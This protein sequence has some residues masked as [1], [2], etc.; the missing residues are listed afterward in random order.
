MSW[1][2]LGSIARQE[3]LP[4]SDVDTALVWEDLPDGPP[5]ARKLQRWADRVLGNME[6]CGLQR[7]VDG[8]NA[9]NPIFAQSKSAFTATAASWIQNPTQS[10]ALLLSSMIAD[11]RPL[12][13]IPLGRAVSDAML[14][15][16]RSREYLTRLLRYST[17]ARPPVGF[18]RNFVV[19]HSG[20]N[21]GQLN[22]KAG[23]LVPIASL[24]RW[25]AI[26]T[27]NDRGTTITRLRRGQDEGLLTTDE[28]DTLIR[29]F[30]YIYGLLLDHEITA[31][32]DG[33][34]APTTWIA[35]R[36]LDTLTRRYLREAFRA[37]A[38]VQ[39]RLEGLWVSRLP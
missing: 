37:V 12:T 13:E 15:T 10:D 28:T 38:E 33:A 7:C 8:A 32:R 9:T 4:R 2:V 11:S 27:G 25:I 23:G 22:L 19:E 30:E 20:E 35:P 24:G 36:E 5:P 39:T 1:L 21:R 6:R 14:A 34:P 18:V 17:T 31:I 29:A 16:T 26:V 3:P